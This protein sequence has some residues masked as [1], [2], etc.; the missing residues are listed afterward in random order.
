M[1]STPPSPLSARGRAQRGPQSPSYW[2]RWQ[3]VFRDFK[4]LVKSRQAKKELLKRL[5]SK[6]FW[7]RKKISYT[8]LSAA[9]CYGMFNLNRPDFQN[10]IYATGL[11]TAG[12]G[13]EEQRALDQGSIV[14]TRLSLSLVNQ[15]T[16]LN[17]LK[18]YG[19]IAREEA[20]RYGVPAELILGLAALL[21]QYG[22]TELALKHNNHFAISCQ[23]N[24][25]DK[26]K[27]ADYQGECLMNY[28][29]PWFSFRALSL[30]LNEYEELKQVAG[31]DWLAWASGLE[32]LGF[33]PKQFSAELL[34]EIIETEIINQN[35]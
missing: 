30:I 35:W 33:P 3:P 20:A 24:P 2:Q 27:Q 29:S 7:T 13:F 4:Q 19:K 22:Q 34:I 17:Y 10:K 25:L 32:K 11:Q 23:I 6:K 26:G 18:R 1:R 5:I 14:Q 16:R 28:P 31:L 8:L 15:S 21:S 9:L 12:L